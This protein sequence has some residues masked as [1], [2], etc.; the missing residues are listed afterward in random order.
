MPDVTRTFI[1]IAIPEPH[2]KRLAKIQDSLRAQLPECRWTAALPFHVTLAFLGDVWNTDLNKL[3]QQVQVACADF[4]PF[5]LSIEALGVFPS[6]ERPRVLWAG[7]AVAEDS[8][9]F[10]LRA[11]VV[12]AAERAGY[13]TDDPRFHPHITLGRIKGEKGGKNLGGLLDRHRAWSA[14]TFRVSE[15]TTFSST[16]GPAGQEYAAVGRARLVRKKD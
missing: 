3:C 1:G 5:E 9:L 6:V 2:D 13:R 10:P 8:P 14:G 11:A 16:T 15:V 4:E 7:V 12:S